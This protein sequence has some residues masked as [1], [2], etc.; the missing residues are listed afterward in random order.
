MAADDLDDD[1]EGGLRVQP[2]WRGRAISRRPFSS[3]CRPDL[4]YQFLP[5]VADGDNPA[6]LL[7]PARRGSGGLLAGFPLGAGAGLLQHPS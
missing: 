3:C 7:L 5:G 2:A 6:S 4:L 1:G